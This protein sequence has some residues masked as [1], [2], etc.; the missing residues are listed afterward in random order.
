VVV[1]SDVSVEVVVLGGRVAVE[2]DVVVVKCVE[3]VVAVDVVVVVW[4]NR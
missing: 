2:R 3:V 4:E 1:F